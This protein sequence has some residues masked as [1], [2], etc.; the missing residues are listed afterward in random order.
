MKTP[1]F[2]LPVTNVLYK[3][4]LWC[5]ELPFTIRLKIYIWWY[6]GGDKIPRDK[7]AKLLGPVDQSAANSMNAMAA[8]WEV[9]EKLEIDLKETNLS[10]PLSR[11]LSQIRD[12][13]EDVDFQ[14]TW[15]KK[16]EQKPLR[17]VVL[18]Y[19]FVYQDVK[20]EKI[21][22]LYPGIKRAEFEE[23]LSAE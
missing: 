17:R 5:H 16:V 15:Y 11:M 18:N 22:A 9:C 4:L 12:T 20:L 1:E 7:I 8:L 10:I 19:L 14:D 13:K 21:E 2:L 23:W 6:G 3:I